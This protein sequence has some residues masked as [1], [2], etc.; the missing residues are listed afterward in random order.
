MKTLGEL[1]STEQTHGLFLRCLGEKMGF[2]RVDCI[3]FNFSLISTTDCPI[4]SPEP[5]DQSFQ[6]WGDRGK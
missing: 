3:C 2:G 1:E 5:L 6:L 4:F